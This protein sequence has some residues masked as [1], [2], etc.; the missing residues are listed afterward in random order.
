MSRETE[1]APARLCP[2][3]CTHRLHETRGPCFARG[4]T[5]VAAARRV[6]AASGLE[7]PSPCCVAS[8]QRLPSVLTV[9]MAA[10]GTPE[11]HPAA[12]TLRLA[13]FAA[14]L[15]VGDRGNVC[16][17]DE[18]AGEVSAAF[19]R[20]PGPSV[21]GRFWRLLAAVRPS[22]RWQTYFLSSPKPCGPHAADTRRGHETEPRPLRKV[23]SL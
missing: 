19:P 1:P 17:T 15:N 11:P 5:Q 10:G 18:G 14:G 8:T 23:S 6:A 13:G 20:D 21:G 9:G 7:A 22:S 4:C 2:A 3:P 12:W 16:S